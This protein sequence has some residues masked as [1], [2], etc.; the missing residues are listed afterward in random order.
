M[1][2]SH[3][4]CCSTRKQ[5]HPDQDDHG[6]G[7]DAVIDR[8]C[9]TWHRGT[10]GIAGRAEV[11]PAE[12]SYFTVQIRRDPR[13]FRRRDTS[14]RTES[15]YLVA[16]SPLRAAVEVSLHND[17]EQGLVHALAPLEEGGEK[18][19]WRSS[20]ISRFRSPAVVA[21]TR[22]RVPLRWVVRS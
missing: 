3:S 6:L 10:R 16:D 15:P 20:G 14:V 19:P 5:G 13:R 22:R 1:E 12:R 2:A 4:L 18:D 9:N 7:D 8:L 17:G 11:P 21:N